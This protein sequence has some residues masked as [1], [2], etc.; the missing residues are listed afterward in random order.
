MNKFLIHYLKRGGK[1]YEILCQMHE[2]KHRKAY[3]LDLIEDCNRNYEENIYKIRFYKRLIEYSYRIS[4]N[5]FS[6]MLST[7][8]KL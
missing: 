1:L 4:W 6:S 3:L 2:H 8:I 5:E 7:A